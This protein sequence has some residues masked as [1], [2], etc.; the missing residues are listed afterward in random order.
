MSN[1]GDAI[2]NL[3]HALSAVNDMT[4]ACRFAQDIILRLNGLCK[5]LDKFCESLRRYL[6]GK[7][8]FNL[9]IEHPMLRKGEKAVKLCNKEIGYINAFRL[10]FDTS[11]M[12][13]PEGT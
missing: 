3:I 6:L 5:D 13:Q 7:P 12:A 2:N 9:S 10:Q 1:V 11:L 8:S 4:L